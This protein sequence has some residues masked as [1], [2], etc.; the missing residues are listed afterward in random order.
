MSPPSFEPASFE[1]PDTALDA[2]GDRCEICGGGPARAETYMWVM[3]FVL[4]TRYLEYAATLCRPCATRTG[5]QEQVKSAL[6]GWWGFPWGLRTLQALWVN[7]RALARWSTLPS[8]LGVATGLAGLLVPALVAV[9]VVV[10]G[11][12]EREA[13]AT[14]DWVD[15]RVVELFERGQAAYAAGDL[16]GAVEHVRAAHDQ[17]P[18]SSVINFT[19][20]QILSDLGRTAEALPYAARSAELAPA[21]I[22]GRALHGYLVAVSQGAEAAAAW[23]EELRDVTPATPED[24][25]FLADFFGQLGDFAEQLRAARAGIALAPPGSPGLVARELQALVELDRRIEAE[26]IVEAVG[27]DVSDGYLAYS[28]D[29]YRMRTETI[30]TLARLQSDWLEV[31][32]TPEAMAGFVRAAERAG[33]LDTVRRELRRWLHDPA[34]PGDAWGQAEPWFGDSWVAELDD[35]LE[36]RPEPLPALLRLRLYDAHGDRLA[37][38]RLAARAR[39]AT[40]HPAT[41]EIDARYFGSLDPSTSWRERAAWLEAHLE[42]APD[43]L[44]C[45]L[46]LADLIARPAPERALAEAATLTAAADV[47][48]PI[49]VAAELVRAESELAQGKPAAALERLT[50]ID[51]AAG[52]P[53]LLPARLDLAIAEAAFHASDSRALSSRLE[54][55]VDDADPEVAAAALLIRWTQQLARDAPVTYREDVDALRARH[56]DELVDHFRSGSLQGILIAE[57]MADRE[58]RAALLPE[59]HRASLDLVRLLSEAAATGEV[60]HE[61]LEAV[62]SGPPAQYAPLLARTAL[63]RRG[64]RPAATGA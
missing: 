51:P 43:H 49:V 22:A 8:G 57:G 45:R 31:S 63:G 13:R 23:A 28:L 25:V 2:T 15:E 64:G 33:Q 1:A 14:G 10:A 38:R 62:A 58:E 54:R 61:A 26:M 44:L 4:V 39:G 35:Y 3:S 37:I 6:V 32:Y 11:T 36:T 5:L 24:A 16:A 46:L 9:S 19:M 48:P 20:A 29:L 18:D 21:S 53:Y 47:H 56:G 12:A 17:A 34:T 60:D 27:D 30:A 50:K 55:L 59:E 52:V 7:A 42:E 40:D 41:P